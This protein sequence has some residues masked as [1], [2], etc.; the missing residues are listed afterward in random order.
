MKRLKKFVEM[1]LFGLVPS[2][3]VLFLMLLIVN[4]F[5]FLFLAKFI[6]LV[7]NLKIFFSFELL[8][9]TLSLILASIYTFWFDS[10]REEELEIKKYNRRKKSNKLK[11]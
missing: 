8:I 10:Y 9:I 5:R 6:S 2:S 1:F 3:I 11:H 4:I 7:S